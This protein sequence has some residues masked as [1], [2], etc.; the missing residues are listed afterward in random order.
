MYDDDDDE[1]IFP[2]CFVYSVPMQVPFTYIFV[3][4]NSNVIQTYI[5]KKLTTIWANICAFSVRLYNVSYTRVRED[6]YSVPFRFWKIIFF[7]CS[8]A[9]MLHTYTVYQTLSLAQLRKLLYIDVN[10]IVAFRICAFKLHDFDI[11]VHAI[12]RDL[13]KNDVNYQIILS[14]ACESVVNIRVWTKGKYFVL[15]SDRKR[16]KFWLIDVSCLTG[17]QM[18]FWNPKSRS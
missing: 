7:F 5:R 2:V 9:Q 16:L 18:Q 10:C 15:D 1:V 17:L 3:S 11:K 4:N 13:G 6:T 8:N 14:E 12:G